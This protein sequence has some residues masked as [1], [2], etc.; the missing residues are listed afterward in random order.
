MG[1]GG[2]ILGTL[3]ALSRLDSYAIIFRIFSYLSACVSPFDF[4]Y[5]RLH[6]ITE[7]ENDEH[8]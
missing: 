6:S 8:K 2:R 5:W 7:R 1:Y 4:I 3:T